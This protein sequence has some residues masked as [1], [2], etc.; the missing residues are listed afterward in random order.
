MQCVYVYS[1]CVCVCK[2]VCVCVCIAHSF[3]SKFFN[4]IYREY[5]MKFLD[6]LGK[7]FTHYIRWYE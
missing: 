3:M 5:L 7:I 6:I 2:C 4:L 1:V